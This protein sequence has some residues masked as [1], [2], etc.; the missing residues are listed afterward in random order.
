[1][2]HNPED[3]LPIVERLCSA[4]DQGPNCPKGDSL[5]RLSQSIWDHFQRNKET[6]Q[7]L[8]RKMKL[9]K[10]IEQ[11]LSF[12]KDCGL[13]VTGSTVT[14]FGRAGSDVDMSIFSK[15]NSN[16]YQTQEIIKKKCGSFQSGELV[17]AKVPVLKLKFQDAEIGTIN[18]DMTFNNPSNVRNTHLLFY[19]SQLDPR[20]RPLVMAVK[21]WAKK[22]GINDPQFMTLSS[23]TL[24]LM[25][26]H[27]LQCG[28][29]PPVLPCLQEKHSEIFNDRRNI[30]DLEYMI[31][32]RPS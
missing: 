20:V 22:N 13:K 30:F 31:M 29:R 16:I 19:D 7:Q 6:R 14:G 32:M 5:A 25:V 23:Y 15:G 18:V 17:N 28:V 10:E 27:Y 4:Q 24:T 3:I 9:C 26:I 12:Q 2:S 1:M 8:E 11:H 21:W